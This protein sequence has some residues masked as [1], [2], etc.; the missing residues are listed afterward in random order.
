MT[1]LTR[2]A[3]ASA[4]LALMIALAPATTAGAGDTGGPHPKPGAAAK[5]AKPPK[6]KNTMVVCNH[7]GYLIGVYSMGPGDVRRS[8]LA[9][10]FDEC[11]TWRH[12]SPGFHDVGFNWRV[13]SKQK[14]VLEMRIKYDGY[15]VYKT[16]PPGSSTLLQLGR[17]KTAKIDYYIPRG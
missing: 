8:D 5:G 2:R 15:T 17:D 14:V 7:S 10:N 13:P 4:A 9:G 12:L 1:Q 16:L 6:P 11:V 3:S